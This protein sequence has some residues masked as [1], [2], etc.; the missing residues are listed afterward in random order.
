MR[1]PCS[2]TSVRAAAS[3][4]VL[5]L[6]ATIAGAAGDGLAASGTLATPAGTWS[7]IAGELTGGADLTTATTN[8]TIPQPGNGCQVI[9]GGTTYTF[10]NSITGN[11]QVL[12]GADAQT[13][14]Q[15]LIEAING[16][17]T[18]KSNGNYSSNLG[19]NA[20]ASATYGGMSAGKQVV[21]L[22]ATSPG[23]W[24]NGQI[25][26][27]NGSGWQYEN[28]GF[29]PGS[30]LTGHAGT[31]LTQAANTL[32]LTSNLA[33]G[34]TVTLGNVTYTFQS[35]TAAAPGQVQIGA[36][37]AATL[38]NLKS[39]VNGNGLNSANP[40]VTASASGNQLTI[41]ARTAGA[42]G[43][44]LAAYGSLLAQPAAATVSNWT[45]TGSAGYL[46]GGG[47]GASN[48][49]ESLSLTAN[50]TDGSTVNV[51]GQTYAFTSGAVGSGQVAIGA[52][53]YATLQNL[54][55]AIAGDTNN[56]ANTAV[57]TLVSGSGNN[58]QIVFNSTASDAA[59]NG[60]VVSGN[61]LAF[62]PGGGADGRRDA[63]AVWPM[64]SFRGK[65]AA[66]TRR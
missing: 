27:V 20:L 26:A 66:A 33:A 49:T 15:H 18:G 57:T 52:N 32:T 16:D 45:T 13:T 34:S 42:A 5:T 59:G 63:P 39:A 65:T 31:D 41:T 56:T 30:I 2:D 38:Q 62:T 3:N 35:G 4:N 7:G 50:L 1:L 51:N 64:G 17:T 11:N 25:L 6:T 24:A 55:G 36:T 44:A 43:N 19:A 14:A 29:G 12:I 22:T 54:A 61:L 48:A 60:V 40:D 37:A 53:A 8:F 28:Y 46:G 10:V 21:V 23:S 47:A 9:L 58:A